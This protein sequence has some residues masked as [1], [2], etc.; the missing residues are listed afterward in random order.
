MG[1]TF[2][3]GA[4]P[5]VGGRLAGSPLRGAGSGLQQAEGMADAADGFVSAQVG[6][7]VED[8]GAEFRAYQHDAQWHQQFA[9]FDRG[10]GGHFFEAGFEGGGIPALFEL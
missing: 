5:R 4:S 7:D 6:G 8:M 3:A 1:A 10:G 9:G 2:R